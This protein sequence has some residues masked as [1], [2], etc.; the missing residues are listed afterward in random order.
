MTLTIRGITTALPRVLG[1]TLLLI[2]LLSIDYTGFALSKVLLDSPLQ[3]IIVAFVDTLLLGYFVSNSQLNGW[4]EWGAVFSMLYGFVYVLTAIESAYLGSVLSVSV[5]P[6]LL[7]NGAIVSG[8]YSGALV[9]LLGKNE[10]PS[11]LSRRLLMGRREWLWKIVVAAAAYL[12]V[13][14]LFG[15]VVYFPL[16]RFLDPSG[17]AAEQSATA[18]SA[19]LVFPIEIVR[20]ALWAILAVPAIITLRFGWKKTALVTGLLLAVPLSATLMLAGTMALGLQIAHLAGIF[21]ENLVFGV[22]VVWILHLHSR[23][24]SGSENFA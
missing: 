8:V 14:V 23:L 12:A 10:T 6:G 4:K 22:L 24:P 18:S 13:F 11:N 19:A 2:A 7:V 20:G 9:V 21:G 1:L 17:L 15:L 16:A 3:L 5:L